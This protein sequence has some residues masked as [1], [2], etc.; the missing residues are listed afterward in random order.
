MKKSRIIRSG[1]RVMQRHKLRSFFMMIGIVVGVLILTLVMSIGRGTE[2]KVMDG[3]KKLFSDS[4]ILITAGGG[5]MKGTPLPF[6]KATTL[7]IADI[8]ALRSD[9]PEIA[10][11]DPMQM[12]AEREVRFRGKSAATRIF[13]QSERSETVWNR[14]VTRGEYFDADA[15]A[16]SSRVA[17]IGVNLAAELF[18][19]ADPIG[20]PI[21]I[22]D[23]PFRVLGL[24]ES[25]G[26][27][28]HG[29]DRDHE[30]IVPISTAMRRLMN[31]DYITAAKL[32]VKDPGRVEQ[33]AVRV[34]EILRVRHHRAPAEVDDFQ[35]ITPV[36]VR[37]MIA[38]MN[39]LFNLLLPLIA[40]IAIFVGGI[41]VANL[42]LVS[43]QERTGEIGLRKAVGARA[44]DILWQF[45]METTVLTLAG[46]VLGILAG[47]AAAYFAAGLMKIPYAV[48]WKAAAAGV[49]FSSLAGILAGVLP[50]RRAAALD[51]VKIL[52]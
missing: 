1:F 26:T 38:G 45:L 24:L 23:V 4:S 44:R 32:I 18:G 40:T 19:D 10:L 3:M 33:T 50:A 48:S 37:D 13:G 31:V 28:P 39:K 22:G 34:Q 8:E 49:V 43:V 47:S 6:G 52:R 51:P 12:I 25:L 5:K 35:I 36:K 42:M 2:I 9:L 30:I 16:S 41:I 15:V 29:L 27:D 46:G 14:G 21:Q 11:W 20:E 7:T 17:L